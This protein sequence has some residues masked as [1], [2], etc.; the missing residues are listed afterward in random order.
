MQINWIGEGID[1]IFSM[2]G[3]WGRWQNNKGRKVCF[4][5]WSVCALY[6]G[7]RDLYLNLFVQ[8]FFCFVSVG[9]HAHGYWNWKK[10]KIGEVK[11][12]GK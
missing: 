10:N 3:K 2:M 11:N 4:L 12:D 1:L 7:C 8:S 5:V 6:W 9:L